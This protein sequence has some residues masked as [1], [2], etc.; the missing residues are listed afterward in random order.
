MFTQSSSHTGYVLSAEVMARR[1]WRV[2]PNRNCY[3]IRM[4]NREYIL[5]WDVVIQRH[6]L[7]WKESGYNGTLYTTHLRHH[8]RY[9]KCVLT[10]H[11]ATSCVHIQGQG[12]H[13]FMHREFP[14]F[15]YQARFHLLH[16]R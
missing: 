7:F 6:S 11:A 14:N 10:V 5:S 16:G 3:S 8:G 15:D 13:I 9:L 4:T 1:Y 12:C 2:Y